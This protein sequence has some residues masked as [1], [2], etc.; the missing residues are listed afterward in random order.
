V[1]DYEEAFTWRRMF[2]KAVRAFQD[3]RT[4]HY[5]SEIAQDVRGRTGRS[6]TCGGDCRRI[7][8]APPHPELGLLP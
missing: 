4:F 5:L 2:E 6:R 8:L 1:N 7:R 3:D